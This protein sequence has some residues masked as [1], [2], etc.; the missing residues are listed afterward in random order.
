[1]SSELPIG[2]G[3]R[4]TELAAFARS[5]LD[6]AHHEWGDRIVTEPG[7]AFS[8]RLLYTETHYALAALLLFLID[9][10]NRE[11]LDLAESRL[12]IWNQGEVPLTFFNAMAICV[13][14]IVFKRSAE[15]H[16]GLQ[17]ILE[18][19]VANTRE[20]R[21]PAYK[22]WCGN[23]AYLQQVAVDTVLLPI[24]RGRHVTDENMDSLLTEFRRYLTPE[25]FFYDLPREGT[26]QEHLLPPTYIMKMLFLAG[27]CHH[28]HPRE[29]LAQLFRSGMASA[30]PL[31]TREGSFSYFG[32]TDNSP[33][34]AGLTIFD[35]R[36]AADLS[37]DLTGEYQNACAAA[38]RYYQTFPRT[39][40]GVLRSNRFADAE[41]DAELARSRDN[42]AYVGQYSLASCAYALLGRYWFPLSN[43]SRVRLSGGL[44]GPA[45]AGHYGRKTSTSSVRP[46]PAATSND[47]GLV[48]LTRQNSELF[49]RTRSEITS[50]DRRYLGPTI[51]RYQVGSRLLIGAISRTVST[52]GDPK[53]SRLLSGAH[54]VTQL[55][56]YRF[57][58]G[59]DQ[60]DGTSVGFVPVV[61]HGAVDY[62]PYKAVS[63]E[64]SPSHLRTRYQMVQLHARGFHPCF[65]ESIE[66]L[67]EHVPGLKPK[68]YSRPKMRL[69]DFIEFSRDVYLEQ[70]RCRIEDRL[71]GDLE[72]KTI[73]FSVRSFPC[74][75]IRLNGMT[76]LQSMIGWGSDGRQTIELYEAQAKHSEIRYE[77]DIELGL[78][79]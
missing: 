56:R 77:C 32:R 46:T 43:T 29:E 21:R 25:G 33:F 70:D 65:I 13:A 1:M 19:L 41:S 57:S 7:T 5:I 62:L 14:A 78:V 40:A 58:R 47:L 15:N 9:R 17:S 66:L 30:L 31:L 36:K 10:T 67:H 68:Q 23:N 59:F 27:L 73:L 54:K 44:S 51:L 75:S 6:A 79:S 49:L 16:P 26:A 53:G 76:K 42:Y 55:F 28:L 4:D 50:W 3:D 34:A 60:L 63:I 69:V 48:K 72:G 38:E 24:A 12:R 20:H 61:R 8:P 35:L 11:W 74:A 18:E 37:P 22:Q 45:E 71:V 39:P 64:T 52:D 2:S